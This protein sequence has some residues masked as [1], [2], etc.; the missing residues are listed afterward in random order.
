MNTNRAR[1]YLDHAA[2]TPLAPEVVD[3]MHLYWSDDFGNPSSIHTEGVAA[4]HAV[5]TALHT[6][7]SVLECKASSLTITGSGTESCNLAIRGVARAAK[8]AHGSSHILTSAIEHHAVLNTCRDLQEHE[9]FELTEAAP[10]KHGLLSVEIIEAALRDDTALVSIMYANNEVGTVQQ[11]RTIGQVCRER[12][13]PF[14]VDACQATGQLPLTVER[15]NVDLFTLN[16]SKAYGPK[17]VGLLYADPRI[18]LAP[19]ITGG[20]QQLNRRAGTV[21]VPLVVGMATAIELAER[22]RETEVPRLQELSAQLREG[23]SVLGGILYG[24]PTERLANNVSVGFDGIDGE[25][26]VLYLD[27]QGISCATGAACTSNRTEPSH[28]LTAMGFGDAE[29]KAAVRFTLG[30]STTATDIDRVL[31]ALSSVLKTLSPN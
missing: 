27:A 5:D 12:G 18:P 7:A 6:I 9:G 11:I 3:A 28:V 30:R 16:A 26:L 13:I 1:L 14:H 2:A 25:T 10:D 23:L 22:Q 17:G 20:S 4:Q 29:A 19:V 31:E 15:L 21:A 24:H 8:R